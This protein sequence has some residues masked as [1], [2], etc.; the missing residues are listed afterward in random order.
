MN[1]KALI[2]IV[3]ILL[4]IGILFIAN[5]YLAKQNKQ[6]VSVTTKQE[7][8]Q[9]KAVP[10]QVEA[11]AIQEPPK[12]TPKQQ[13]AVK[14]LM[15]KKVFMGNR[16]FL[17]KDKVSTFIRYSILEELKKNNYCKEIIEN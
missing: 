2:V 8:S 13:A 15:R 1:K 14:Q 5:Q 10:A 12:E 11:P 9:V 7:P 4:L 6:C 3:L 16:G 17:I